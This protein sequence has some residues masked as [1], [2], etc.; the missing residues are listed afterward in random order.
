MAHPKGQC[1]VRTIPSMNEMLAAWSDGLSTRFT[2][3]PTQ[4]GYH[5]TALFHETAPPCHRAFSR[6]RFLITLESVLSLPGDDILDTAA[7]ACFLSSALHAKGRSVTVNDIRSPEPALSVWG[8]DS[9]IRFFSKDIFK[10]EPSDTGL[11]DVLVCAELIEHVAHPSTLLAHL[12][13]FLRPGGHLVITTPNGKFIGSR[14]PTFSEVSNFEELESRQFRP[15]SDGHLMLMTPEE[16][17]DLFSGSGL[18]VTET[19]LFGSPAINGHLKLRHL[20]RLRL[21]SFWYLMESLVHASPNRIASR[22]F[23]HMLMIGRA[24]S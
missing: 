4:S 10:L 9:A 1:M 13:K 5:D 18:E 16:L 24:H 7:G 17:G 6:L 20:S 14:L 12:R 19:V 2:R 22:V 3:L 11:F 15:D 21:P 8:L 23:T